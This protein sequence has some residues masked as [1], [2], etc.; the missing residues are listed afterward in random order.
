MKTIIITIVATIA[1]CIAIIAAPTNN[2]PTNAEWNEFLEYE[3][4]FYSW[5]DTE[6]PAAIRYQ[7]QDSLS[8]EIYFTGSLLDCKQFLNDHCA[9]LD[10]V[11][12]PRQ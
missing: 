6:A 3:T 4:E 9:T 5:R 1:C 7:V 12:L 10:C 2:A 8:E 11:I